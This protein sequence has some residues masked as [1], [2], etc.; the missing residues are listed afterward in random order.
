MPQTY[1]VAEIRPDQVDK[2]YALVNPVAPALQLEEWRTFCER[3]RER[4]RASGGYVIVATNPVGY[5]KG[6]C[7]A[8]VRDHPVHGH[9]LDVPI[10][11][12]TSAADD[13]VV[14]A[15]MLSYLKDI[16]RR[17]ACERL[18][19]WTLDNDN[20]DRLCREEANPPE[21]EIVMSLGGDDPAR[22][23]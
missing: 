16:G 3:A 7:I 19:L 5:I 11:A 22:A 10:F 8:A 21:R 6:L 23:N 9:I 1:A 20:W 18:R 17:A 2:C 4:G 12:A 15:D 13:S 14:A